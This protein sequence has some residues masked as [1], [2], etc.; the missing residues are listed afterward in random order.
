M[1]ADKFS[2][3]DAKTQREDNNREWIR[4]RQAYGATGYE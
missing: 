2:R 1:D 4:F 3:K